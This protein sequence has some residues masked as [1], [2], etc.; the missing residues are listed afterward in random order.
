LSKDATIANR[1]GRKVSIDKFLLLV[2]AGLSYCGL[3]LSFSSLI[4]L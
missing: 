1:S 4:L 2:E 3:Q